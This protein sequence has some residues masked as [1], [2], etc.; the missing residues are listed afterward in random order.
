MA[1][2]VIFD[3]SDADDILRK[4]KTHPEYPTIDT[5][6]M[7]DLIFW[8]YRPAILFG[9][10]DDVEAVIQMCVESISFAGDKNPALFESMIN[11]I[12]GLVGCMFE[13]LDQHQVDSLLKAGFYYTG[14]V[15][16]WGDAYGIKYSKQRTA[17]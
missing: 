14:I 9:E 16:Q 10:H 4:L 8:Q 2:V 11:D 15:G 12:A 6:A 1:I 17:G 3:L 13:L 7:M 5:V